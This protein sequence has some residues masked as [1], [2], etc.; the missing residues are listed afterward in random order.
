MDKFIYCTDEEIKNKL[1][2]MEIPLLRE[3]NGI[4]VFANI[5]SKHKNFKRF[6]EIK[7]KVVF[8]NKMQF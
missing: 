4:F 6:E 2:D 1:I 8:T 7:N 3:S 5:K